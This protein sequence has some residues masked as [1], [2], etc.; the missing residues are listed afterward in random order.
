MAYLYQEIMKVP[1]LSGT[2]RQRQ[3]QLFNR[4]YPGQKYNASYEQNINLLKQIQSGNYGTTSG[5][6]ASQPN[7]IEQ[8]AAQAV[9]SIKDLPQKSFA[10]QY[11]TEEE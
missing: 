6:T 11:G 4:L 2:A 7:T 3:E 10:D 1:G 5:Q 8:L 9:A